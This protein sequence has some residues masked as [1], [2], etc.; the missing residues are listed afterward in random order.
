MKKLISIIIPAYN[1]EGNINELA[2][3]L[4]TVFGKNRRYHFE[5]VVVDNGSADK[6]FEKLLAVRQK[7]KRFKILQLS[8]NF[9]CDDGIAAGLHFATGDAG[10]IMMADLQD[11]PEMISKFID[12]WEQGYEMVYGIVSQR[13]KIAWTRELSTRLFYKIINIL[14][15]GRLPENVS[16]F[17]LIDKRVYQVINAMPEHNKFMRGMVMWTGFSSTGIKFKRPPRF[18]GKS[19]ADFR[20]VFKVALNGIFSF[21]YFPLKLITFLG[22]ALSLITFSLIIMQLTRYAINVQVELGKS[23]FIILISFLFGILFLILGVIGEYL[24]RIYDEVKGR[25]NF[26]VRQK[27]GL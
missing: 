5:V 4:R 6:T 21:S 17:R 7:D 14:T 3:R 20:T 18:A 24:A 27:I 13:Q 16:D 19:K 12:K 15:Q 25:P 10:I 1:E 9:G 23:I 2:K 11:P 26:V 8:R 22:V